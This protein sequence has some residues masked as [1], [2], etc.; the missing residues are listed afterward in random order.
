MSGNPKPT[1]WGGTLAGLWT[2]YR[3]PCRPSIAELAVCSR[4]I[5][6]LRA[7]KP[8]DRLKLLVLGST[9]EFRDLAFD[10]GL[11]VTVIDYSAAYHEK[12]RWELRHKNANERVIYQRWQD[13]TFQNEFDLIVGDLVVGNLRKHELPGFL[14]NVARA[15]TKDGLFLTK[16]FFWRDDH[17]P[18]SLI[19]IFHRYDEQGRPPPMFPR[20]IYDIALA[21]ADPETRILKFRKMYD[22]LAELHQLG[23]IDDA[24]YQPFTELG[25]QDN[26]KFEFYIPLVS[27]WEGDL[28]RSLTLVRKEY[29]TDVYSPNFPVYISSRQD[30]R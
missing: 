6:E 11:D 10:E 29:G 23:I 28:K 20:L 17:T 1:E 9:T 19:D 4:T 12:I 16:S 21:C 3:P 7:S 25:W 15:L 26:M 8:G 27:E 30:S 24:T 18:R 13:M 14:N 2:N 5:N 22:S